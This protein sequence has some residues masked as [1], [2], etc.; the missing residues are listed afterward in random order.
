MP[1]RNPAIAKILGQERP[2]T[3]TETL[4]QRLALYLVEDPDGRVQDII[5][6]LDAQ[7][8][9]IGDAAVRQMLEAVKS[10]LYETLASCAKP[11]TSGGDDTFFVFKDGVV[12]RAAKALA[13]RRPPLRSES[14][15]HAERVAFAAGELRCAQSVCHR[16]PEQCA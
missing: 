1:Q 14:C 9:F 5:R 7:A 6:T 12:T 3:V 13:N 8:R 2:Q 10:F 4:E 16:A 15:I 11:S